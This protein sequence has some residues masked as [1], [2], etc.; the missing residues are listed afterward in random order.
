MTSN[1]TRTKFR[2]QNDKQTPKQGNK[3]NYK[4]WNLSHTSENTWFLPQWMCSIL[5]LK[6]LQWS[7]EF[8]T[9]HWLNYRLCPN[10]SEPS[11]LPPLFTLHTTQYPL[12][13]PSKRLPRESD[14]ACPHCSQVCASSPVQLPPE[15]S[16]GD[17]HISIRTTEHSLTSAWDIK[18]P[19]YS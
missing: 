15:I 1:K 8:Q 11:T 19:V 3:A 16:Q 12:A 14:K 13:Q 6:L 18:L 10:R 7:V 17:T 2:K 4:P 9:L 5:L